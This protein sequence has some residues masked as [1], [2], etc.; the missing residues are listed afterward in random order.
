MFPNLLHLPSPIYQT[1]DYIAPNGNQHQIG[2]LRDDAVHP[3][4]GG[5]KYRKLQGAV[6]GI[7]KGIITFGG[8]YSNHLLATAYLCKEMKW[9][10]LVIIRGEDGWND[11]L[12]QIKD[13][14][15][16]IYRVSRSEY[17]LK[18]ERL[19]I[20]KWLQA[21]AAVYHNGM[22]PSLEDWLVIPEGG[23]V[24]EA[25]NSCTAIVKDIPQRFDYLFVAAGTG[26]T[27]AGLAA[28]IEPDQKLV[29]VNVLNNRTEVVDRL[30]SS[31]I[32]MDRIIVTDQFTFGG[33]GK[34]DEQLLAYCR[35]FF[36]MYQ[37]PID[38][39]YTGKLCYAL[40]NFIQT[41]KIKVTDR[42]AVYHSGGV[43]QFN[44]LMKKVKL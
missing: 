35:N 18:T 37:I 42:V 2:F 23:A 24:N 32:N 26:T 11:L 33:Y 27:A 1:I 28:A 15:I 4:L 7:T 40:D 17:K 3:Y 41:G 29:V 9:P 38:P 34:Y 25:K 12:D 13:W 16:F 36:L 30:T 8:A 6:S 21:A 14:G 31:A 5:N 43:H 44:P 19:Q 10:G 22:L 39:I 20:A